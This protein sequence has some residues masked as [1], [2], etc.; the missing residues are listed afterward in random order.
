MEQSLLIGLIIGIFCII[1][2]ISVKTFKLD[3]M[4]SGYNTLPKE[5]KVN[6]KISKIRLLFLTFFVTTGTILTVN[7]FISLFVEVKFIHPIGIAL[8][9]MLFLIVNYKIGKFD[10][11]KKGGMPTIYRIFHKR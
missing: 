11:N 10:Y 1:L 2:G 4:I 8:I 5:K 6:V 7:V 9:V 3:W